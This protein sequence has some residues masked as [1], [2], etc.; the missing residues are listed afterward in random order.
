[1]WRRS[2]YLSSDNLNILLRLCLNI[3]RNW[4]GT[5]RDDRFDGDVRVRMNFGFSFDAAPAIDTV[6]YFRG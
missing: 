1:M 5:D 3:D 6:L 2:L 4:I